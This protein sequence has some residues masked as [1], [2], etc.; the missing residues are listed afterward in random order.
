MTE[1]STVRVAAPKILFGSEDRCMQ[2]SIVHQGE[3]CERLMLG[4]KSHHPLLIPRLVE[5]CGCDVSFE[6]RAPRSFG[7]ALGAH[8]G[9]DGKARLFDMAFPEEA[10]QVCVSS[11]YCVA[12][13]IVLLQ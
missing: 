6:G 9:E 13:L 4:M 1:S 3:A 12:N 7:R 8:G 11:E 2:R 5:T 10:S